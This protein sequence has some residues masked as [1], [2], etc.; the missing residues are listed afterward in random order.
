MDYLGLNISAIRV[1][2]DV[3]Q[4]QVLVTIHST[5]LS[6]SNQ[7]RF[8]EWDLQEGAPPS[9]DIMHFFKSYFHSHCSFFPDGVLVGFSWTLMEP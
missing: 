4:W 9:S 5:G 2:S 8:H 6:S 7:T 3:Q 1:P